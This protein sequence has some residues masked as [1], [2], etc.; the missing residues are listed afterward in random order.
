MVFL[1]RLSFPFLGL[2]IF[3]F[4]SCA[5]TPNVQPRIN[6]LVAAHRLE[7]ANEVLASSLNAYGPNNQL[8]YWL[9]RGFIL[10][11]LGNF[12]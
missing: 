10:H 9:D 3:F 6:S 7:K 11:L 12:S 4:S 8:L 2:C 1:R 5:G